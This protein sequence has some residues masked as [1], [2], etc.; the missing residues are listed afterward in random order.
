M[1]TN[2]CTVCG[3]PQLG[4]HYHEMEDEWGSPEWEYPEGHSQYCH[5][6]C[7]HPIH[8]RYDEWKAAQQMPTTIWIVGQN[9]AGY[10]PNSSPFLTTD[11]ESAKNSLADD[12]ERWADSLVSGLTTL[13]Y[14]EDGR[15]EYTAEQAL[16]YCEAHPELVLVDRDKETL[17]EIAQ[18]EAAIESLNNLEKDL[19]WG[20]YIGNEYYWMHITEREA[21]EIPDDLEGDELEDFIDMLNE[22]GY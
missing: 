4:I 5:K 19:E 7:E 17:Q 13:K 2:I 15:E 21:N 10:M 20:Y 18:C 14:F 3:A 22:M 11:W 12:I 8:K 6:D 9:L 1:L 16:E